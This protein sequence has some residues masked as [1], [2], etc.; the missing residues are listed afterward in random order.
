LHS[1]TLGANGLVVYPRL[2]AR[3]NAVHETGDSEWK[4]PGTENDLSIGPGASGSE[5]TGRAAFQ[6]PEL[7]GLLGGGL[8]RATS[9]LVLGS[10]GTGKTLL[11]LHFS[12]AG[13][14]AGEPVLYLGFRENY[15]QLLLKAEA[16][17]L[18]EQLRAALAPGGGLTLVRRPPIELNPDILADRLL[19]LL[20]RTGAQRLVLDSVAEVESAVR[21]NGDAQRP[22]NYMSALVEALEARRVTTLFIKETANVVTAELALSADLL[23]VVAENVV[24]MQQVTLRSQLHRVLSVPKMRYSAHDVTLREFVI[25]PPAGIRVLQPF[26]S[27]NGVLA[28]FA[29]QHAVSTLVPT[30]TPHADGSPTVQP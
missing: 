15:R 22:A 3:I 10:L 30:P 2:E 16:F 26:E 14:R 7:D 8:T 12:L 17:D 20:D 9:T 5:T 1:V 27:G 11:G 6:L 23:A 25:A 18:G 29:G 4:A 24:W 28:G 19:G 13:V 21:Q